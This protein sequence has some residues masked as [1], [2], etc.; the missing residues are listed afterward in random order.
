MTYISYNLMETVWKK[1]CAKAQAK[2]GDYVLSIQKKHLKE[3]KTLSKFATGHFF[4]LREDA[5][6]VGLYT[7]VVVVEAF[8]RLTPKPQKVRRPAIDR[9]WALPAAALS[10]AVHVLEPH[11]AQY[12]EDAL[13]E[14]DDKVVLTDEELA[15]CS[16]VVQTA[17]LCLHQAC[18]NVS[19]A[20][21]PT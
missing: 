17:I 2:G 4:E 6:G 12:L 19:S 10:Q 18:G 21:T 3:Q 8:S 16:R 20:Q 5:A 7:F 9:V 11:A 13:V 15:Y 14:D 1:V